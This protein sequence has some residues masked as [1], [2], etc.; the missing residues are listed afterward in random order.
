MHG[1]VWAAPRGSARRKRPRRDAEGLDR[2]NA[3]VATMSVKAKAKRETVP[4]A[5]P[6]QDLTEA[7]GMDEVWIEGGRKL[8]GTVA[9]SGSKNATLPML[10][11][12]LL[13][14]GIY[15]FANVP[16]LRDITTMLEL[17][18]LFGLKS[19]REDSGA[20]FADS[21]GVH[22]AEAP[23]DLVKTMRAS[24]YVLG[25]LLA[26]FG[27]ARVS[28]PGG[29]AWGPRPVDLHIRGMQRLGADVE[30][31]HGYIVARSDR[32][33][34]RVISSEVSSVGATGNL[35][36]AAATAEGETVLENA[37]CEP[38]IEAL[39]RFL[40]DMG[41]K[42]EGMGRSRLAVTGT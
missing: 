20:L 1:A 32:L 6:P 21:T 5:A 29:C 7:T 12:T 27:E 39:A 15:R 23:Y 37:A 31:E 40:A 28:L 24:I 38:E 4:P 26:R 9:V 36:M 41:A 2:K 35:L 8:R 30:I 11:A 22:N 14:P 33:R 3:R 16:A 17:L 19:R 18:S 10:T 42:I 34:G 13:A 25:P